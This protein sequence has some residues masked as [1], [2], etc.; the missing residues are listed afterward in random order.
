MI[1]YFPLFKFYFL[2]FPLQLLSILSHKRFTTRLLS[3]LSHKIFTTILEFFLW[4]I[5]FYL[6]MTLFLVNE[7]FE[8]QILEE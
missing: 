8:G 4:G 5:T 7:N 1:I 3:I 2:F 6:N